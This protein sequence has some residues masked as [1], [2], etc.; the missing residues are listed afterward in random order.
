MKNQ[1]ATIELSQNFPN[2]LS[3]TEVASEIERG[4]EVTPNL[5]EEKN[6]ISA[7]EGDDNQGISKSLMIIESQ[8]HRHLEM[9]RNAK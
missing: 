4:D 2:E 5:V 3:C 6:E 1:D 8:L 7:N 9:I